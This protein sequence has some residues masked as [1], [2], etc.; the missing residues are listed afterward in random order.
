MELLVF[1][2]ALVTADLFAF[3]YGH[4]SR[5]RFSWN[6]RDGALAYDERSLTAAKAADAAQYRSAANELERE[7][8]RLQ[9]AF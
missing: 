8:A 6:R 4:D 7:L 1:V 5:D 9:R 2:C 3:R